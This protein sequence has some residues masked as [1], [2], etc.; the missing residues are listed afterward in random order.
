MRHSLQFRSYRIV[1]D[2][3]SDASFFQLGVVHGSKNSMRGSKARN[4]AVEFSHSSFVAPRLHPGI[5]SDYTLPHRY[6]VASPEYYLG[7]WC[8]NVGYCHGISLR[9]N[10]TTAVIEIPS[11]RRQED[12]RVVLPS[13]SISLYP[14]LSAKL[15]ILVSLSWRKTK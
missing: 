8:V 1:G 2:L 14:E 3:M 10:F 13:T 6:L 11:Q 4:C 9:L 15:T 7:L 12:P 5:A